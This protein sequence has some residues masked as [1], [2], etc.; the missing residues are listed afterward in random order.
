[1]A[2]MFNDT[3]NVVG[4]SLRNELRGPKQNV[5][6]WY[7]GRGRGSAGQTK[8]SRDTLWS[9]LRQRPKLPINKSQSR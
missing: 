1:M 9:Q 4:M 3:A 2:T 8:C 6:D 7:K 5:N